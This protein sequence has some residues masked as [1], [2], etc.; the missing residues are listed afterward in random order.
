MSEIEVKIIKLE[1]MRVVSAYGFGAEPEGVAWEKLKVFG[2]E[3]G[4]F[5]EGVYPKTYGFNN[6]N[7]SQGSP[8][9]GYEIWLPVAEGVEPDGNL[10]V[11]NFSGGLYAVTTFKGLE[12]IGETW[13]KLVKWREGSKYKQA[14][15]QW[16]EE[17]TT[18]PDASPE[19]YVFTIYLPISE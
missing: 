18:E 15:H 11:V 9:Y 1:E 2:L 16:M 8:N 3:K 12:N 7:P 17:L 19:E 5:K 6:P 4:L 10:R 14:H 13:G